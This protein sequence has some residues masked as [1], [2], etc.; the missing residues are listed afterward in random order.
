MKKHLKLCLVTNRTSQSIPEY[1]E[2]IKEVVSAGITM[3]QLRDK[4]NNIEEMEAFAKAL[5]EILAPKN[6][7]LIINDNVM[8]AKAINANGVHIGNDDMGIKQARELL[9]SDKIIGIS[10]ESLEDLERANQLSGNYYVAASAVFVSKTKNN[11]KKIWG[12]DG[13]EYI[14]KNSNHPVIAI[15]NINKSNLKDVMDCGASGVAV[16]SAIHD[17]NSPYEATLDLSKI[18]ERQYD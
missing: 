8:L 14:V 7:P 18:I 17:D 9:G 3:V 2:F 10:I 5:Q 15:G 1:L 6:I 12:L 11:C 16:I 4:S 13:L